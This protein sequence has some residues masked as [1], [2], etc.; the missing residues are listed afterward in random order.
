[1]RVAILTVSDR[2]ARG[3]R[4][5]ASGPALRAAVEAKGHGVVAAAVV[6]DDR[7][8]IAA[9]IRELG[10]GAD[11]VLTTGGTGCSPRDVTPEATRDAVAREIPGLPEEIRRRSAAADPRGLL[12]RGVAGILPGGALVLNLPGSPGGAVECFGWV[13]AALPHAAA[14]A[15]G[16][17]GDCGGGFPPAAGGGR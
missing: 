5:D 4:P 1:V 17:V 11:L 8:T 15:R 14:V 2:S 6:P 13:A 9:R 12:S 7:G 16:G 10:E 3:E